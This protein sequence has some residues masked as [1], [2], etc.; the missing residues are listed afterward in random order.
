M[1]SNKT[2]P[3]MREESKTAPGMGPNEL[4]QAEA[5]EE[6]VKRGD[7]TQVIRLALDHTP[8]D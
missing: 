6:E 2:K 3:S 8:E 7:Y 5:T 4:L 1:R